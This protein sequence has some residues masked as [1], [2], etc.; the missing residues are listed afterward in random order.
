MDTTSEEAS[1]SPT[2]DGGKPDITSSK[3]A[4][5][6]VNFL[7]AMGAI[8]LIAFWSYYTSFPGLISSSGIEPVGRWMPYATPSIHRNLIATQH[9][10]ADSFCELSA[11]L[12]MT[13]SCIVASGW[14]QHGLLFV[15]MTFLY[16]ILTRVGG[17]FYSFQWDTLLLEVAFLTAVCYA[18]WTKLRPAGTSALGAWPLRFL[19]FKLMYMSGVVKIQSDCPT[20]RNLTALEYHFATQ[21]LPGPLAWYFHQLHP[22]LLRFSVAASLWI[23]IPGTILLLLTPFPTVVRIGAVLQILLQLVII[24]TGNYNFFNL[25]TIVLCMVC[26]ESDASKQSTKGVSLNPL[27][28][29]LKAFVSFSDSLS[30]CNRLLFSASQHGHSS[31]GLFLKCLSLKERRR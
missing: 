2:H 4:S 1:S 15:A 29:D 7:S 26:L 13:L 3:E 10:D 24:L 17:T 6:R 9:I 20:W 23:E 31:L 12:G 28:L 30:S 25:V 8:F 14:I 22:F 18:P 16:S 27:C 19:L 21:C 11:L 5:L